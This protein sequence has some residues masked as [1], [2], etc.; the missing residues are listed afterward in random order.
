MVA[1]EK[2]SCTDRAMCTKMLFEECEGKKKKIIEEE[3]N[4]NNNKNT[5]K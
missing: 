1:G 2:Y 5:K 3:N 4:N